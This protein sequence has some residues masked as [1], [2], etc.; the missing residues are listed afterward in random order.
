MKFE[1]LLEMVSSA[2]E[3]EWLGASELEKMDKLELEKRAIMGW[4]DAMSSYKE[5][6][7]KIITN[8]QLMDTPYPIWYKGLVDAVFHEL[9]GLAG[10]APWAYDETEEYRKSSSAKLIG[11]RLY[12]LIDGKSVLQPQRISKERREQLKR[13]FLMSKPRERLEDGFHELY[14]RNGIRITVFSGERTKENQDVIVFRK[15]V[16]SELSFE[17]MA[18]LE[19]IPTEAIAI[20]KD[21]IRI[22]FNVLFAGPVRSGKT[23][24][25]QTWQSY[26][27][28]SLEGLTIATD[29]ETKWEKIMPDAPIMQLVADGEDLSKIAKSLLRGDN[30]YVLLEEMRDAQAYSLALDITSTGTQRSKATIHT[31]DPINLPYRMASKIRSEYGADIGGTLI[32]IFKNFNYIFEFCQ[33]AEDRSQK[34]LLGIWE[35]CYDTKLDQPSIH[36]IL[37]YDTEKHEWEWHY[38]MGEDKREIAGLF[39]NELKEMEEEMKLLESRNPIVSET[40]IYPKYYRSQVLSETEKEKLIER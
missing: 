12:C 40:V 36:Q 28:K 22:G 23:T 3:S 38:H 20:F 21:M 18:E 35:Y 5:K 25:L 29:P 39:P 24:F 27:D 14:L 15:Y 31:S 4:P 30:D 34:K 19:T 17:K 13:A 16:M 2:L 37:K 26:E 10:I 9:Y 8:L 6:I 33:V 1:E 32:Q 7:A 11:D